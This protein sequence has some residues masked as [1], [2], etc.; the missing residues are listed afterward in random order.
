LSRLTTLILK[1][2]LPPFITTFFIAWFVLLMQFL[3]YFMEKIAG[4]GLSFGL[5]MELIA[6]K[7]VALLP[8][9]I[10]LASLV[11]GVMVIG[12]LAEHYEL[13]AI[14]SAGRSL[15]RI[16]TPLALAGLVLSGASYLTADYLIPFTNLQFLQRLSDVQRKKPDLSIEAGV[17]N[18]DLAHFNV[19]AASRNPDT[20]ELNDVRLYD[21]TNY[22]SD[23][24]VNQIVAAKGIFSEGATE[25]DLILTLHNGHHLREKTSRQIGGEFT[26]TEF[27]T[28]QLSFDL[29][30]FDLKQVTDLAGSDHYALLSTWELKRAA[31][32]IAGAMLLRRTELLTAEAKL[33]RITLKRNTLLQGTLK[34]ALNKADSSIPKAALLPIKTA[35]TSFEQLPHSRKKV[36]L[37]TIRNK[38]R[39]F[40]QHAQ[41]VIKSEEQE[42]GR[43]ERYRF[44][45]H[46]KFGLAVVCLLFVLIGGSAGAVVRKGGFGYPILTGI[47]CFV[48]YILVLEF[49]RR[50]MKA[51]VLSGPEAAWV[52]V[53]VLGLVAITL[54][55]YASSR[56]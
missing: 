44:E 54:T 4:K 36:L 23:P 8:L 48:S 21:Q 39:H 51:A 11:A 40:Q 46:G 43:Y 6:Y 32:S 16:L 41:R 3:W 55:A 26:R 22:A 18:E 9:A 47:G 19:Y 17:F 13:V 20:G 29:S 30:Q 49:C 7:S 1:S 31:D 5:V 42:R 15:R 52:P 56:S 35:P 25:G 2:F 33:L 27:K 24:R 38:V 37:T 45:R 28:Y 10:P 14:H 53:L 34:S 50:L 12:G